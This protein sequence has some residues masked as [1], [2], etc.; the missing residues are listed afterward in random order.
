MVEPTSQEPNIKNVLSLLEING[1]GGS[2]NSSVNSETN[3]QC[4]VDSQYAIIIEELASSINLRSSSQSLN[5][6]QAI[7]SS[8]KRQGKLFVLRLTFQL[9]REDFLSQ[10]QSNILTTI[11]NKRGAGKCYLPES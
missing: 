10:I 7:S 8:L 2:S 6:Q 11:I 9:K 5:N 1:L 3:K 4:L